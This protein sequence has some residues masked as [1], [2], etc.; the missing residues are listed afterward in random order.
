MNYKIISLIA[1][2]V[3][4]VCGCVSEQ[5][6]RERAQAQELVAEIQKC[7]RQGKYDDANRLCDE[8]KAKCPTVEYDWAK[9]KQI[10]ERQKTDAAKRAEKERAEKERREK[11]RVENAKKARIEAENRRR[12]SVDQY[13]VAVATNSVEQ[14]IATYDQNRDGYFVKPYKNPFLP[15]KAPVKLGDPPKPKKEPGESYDAWDAKRKELRKQWEEKKAKLKEAEWDDD[16]LKCW[17]GTR[18][19]LTAEEAKKGDAMLDAFGSKKMPKLYA[20]YD[21]ARKTAKEV[22]GLFNENFPKPW[23]LKRTSAEWQGY[24]KF[25]RK[26]ANARTEY[27]RRHDELC[28]FYAL[29]R[30]GFASDSDLTKIDNEPLFVSI[31]DENVER[32]QLIPAT[33]PAIDE[34]V[35]EFVKKCAPETY[36]AY[37]KLCGEREALSKQLVDVAEEMRLLDMTRYE[38]GLI[39]YWEAVNSVVAELRVLTGEWTQLQLDYKLLEK[40]AAAVAKWDKERVSKLQAFAKIVPDLVKSYIQNPGVPYGHMVPIP[41]KQYKAGRTEVT[42]AQWISVMGTNP[43]KFK[44]F[45]R[46][47]E[48]VSNDDCQLFIARLNTRTSGRFHLPTCDE[49]RYA[50]LA[51]SKGDWGLLASG[52]MG[53][54]KDLGWAGRL[55]K[56]DRTQPVALKAPNAFGLYDMHGNVKEWTRDLSPHPRKDLRIYFYLGGSWDVVEEACVARNKWTSSGD[57]RFDHLGFRLFETTEE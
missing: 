25:L 23:T 11:E 8:G 26:F 6:L 27:F 12:A 5:E 3:A 21:K 20:E 46:P 30:I 10:V 50:C 13:W 40:D 41:G 33:Q 42:Q 54:I 53:D 9:T 1:A 48:Q 28:H 57:S 56:D 15:P 18:L 52:N 44:G 17:V 7:V 22:Q 45:D 38:I 32:I 16:W 35:V 29:N 39:S 51:G 55:V 49:W 2:S 34:K 24:N 36:A 47:V 14:I 19:P 31:F 43:S 37:Q 4:M